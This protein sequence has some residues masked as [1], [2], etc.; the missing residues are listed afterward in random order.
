[1]LLPRVMCVKLH[2]LLTINHNV[3]QD[4]FGVEPTHRPG[5][6]TGF[7]HFLIDDRIGLAIIDET[8]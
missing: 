1:V 7:Y 2:V 3:D 4:V 5:Y 6:L 8:T